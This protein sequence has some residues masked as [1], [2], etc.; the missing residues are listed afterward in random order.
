[1]PADPQRVL[2]HLDA[3]R[4]IAGDG[5]GAQS[6]AWTPKWQEVRAWFLT[7]LDGLPVEHHMDAA[8]N[9]WVTLPGASPRAWPGA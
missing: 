4:G 5:N 1:M 9:R 2:A 6:V 8:G 3:L 7:L